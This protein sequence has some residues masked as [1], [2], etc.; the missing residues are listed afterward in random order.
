MQR[1]RLRSFVEELSMSKHEE[2]EELCALAATG[3]LAPEEELRLSEHLDACPTCRAACEEYSVILRELPTSDRGILEHDVV[4][5]IEENGFRDRFLTR[6]R[7]EG[8]RFSEEVEEDTRSTSWGFFR[9]LPTYQG[10]AAGVMIVVLASLIAFRVFYHRATNPQVVDAGKIVSMPADSNQVEDKDDK[11][12]KRV[13]ELHLANDASQKTTAELKTENAQLLA[14]LEALEK[15]LGASRA[16]KAELE[17]TVSRVSNMNGQLAGQ[18]DQNTQVLAQ[19][20]A[21]LEKARADR[22]SMQSEMTAAKGEVSDLSRQVRLQAAS[23][24]EDKQL[25]FAGRD[26]TDL[27]GARNLHI[28]DVHDA[29]GSGKDKQS[30]G[31]VFYTEGRRLIFYAFDLDENKV[32]NAKYTFEAWG[33]RLGQPTSV[34]SLGILYADDKNQRRWVL[35]VDDPQRLA[36]I[37]SV[38]VTL[39]PRDGGT[40]KPRGHKILYAFL[41]GQANHP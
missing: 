11:L 39:E 15:E 18:M 14:H 9:W 33:E 41:S 2:F 25:L 7:G 4:R 21:E 19:T 17:R 37:D 10:I 13:S 27:M 30:F 35:K 40:E 1:I 31:R 29:D 5:Q 23:L 8:R 24:E 36:Q 38:F 16:D 6:A 12:A 26:I 34:K 28:I 20:N 3:Q 32:V 22:T